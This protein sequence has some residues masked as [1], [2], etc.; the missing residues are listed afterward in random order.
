MIFIHNYFPK[1]TKALITSGIMAMGDGIKLTQHYATPEEYRFNALGKREGELF[2]L[3]KEYASCFYIDR[4]QGGTFYSEYSW[5]NELLSE[6]EG[7]CPF[8]GFQLHELGTTR[9]LDWTR[10]ERQL[11]ATGLPRTEDGVTEAIRQIS[12]NK[13]V[14]HLSQGRAEEYADGEMPRTL[15]KAFDDIR[16]VIR[17]AK[18]RTSGRVFNCDA[19]TSLAAMDTEEGLKLS[20]IEVGCQTLYSRMQYAVRRGASRAAGGKWGVYLEPWAHM[21]NGTTC[22]CFMRDGSNEWFIMGEGFAYY[23]DGERGGSSMSYAKR[24]MFYTLFSGAD[25]FSEEWGQ[26]NTFRDPDFTELSPYG[27]IK[28]D[29]SEFARRFPCVK[30]YIPVAIVIPREYGVFNTHCRRF[31]YEGCE[32]DTEGGRLIEVAKSIVGLMYSGK[33]RGEEDT[34]EGDLGSEDRYFTV[35]D[36]GSIFDIIFDDSYTDPTS[37]YDLV[38]DYSG[39]LSGERIVCGFDGDAVRR[40]LDAVISRLPVKLVSSGEIDYS[41]FEEDGRHFVA[42]YNH[43]GVSKD[44]ELGETV[45][46]EAEVTVR[47]TAAGAIKAIEYLSGGEAKITSGT[48]EARLPGGEFIVFEYNM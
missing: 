39:R 3:V 26:A 28:K 19:G 22:Y 9:M 30:P 36:Y 33:R 1:Y 40:A 16:G 13:E 10:V 48:L 15:S 31:P 11:A 43:R 17:R 25:Y 18:K 46:K 24:T 32:D 35:G 41:F 8:L 2:S 29:F 44:V 4:L 47:A 27:I 21:K 12:A 20:F 37:E 7:L 34:G 14:I 38:I 45:A 23:H 5:D 42:V 6:Y